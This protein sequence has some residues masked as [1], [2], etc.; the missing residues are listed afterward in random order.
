MLGDKSVTLHDIVREIILIRG[1]LQRIGVNASLYND[2][3]KTELETVRAL[4]GETIYDACVY[5]E[6]RMMLLRAGAEYERNYI[7][8]EDGADQICVNA[9]IHVEPVKNVKGAFDR[10]VLREVWAPHTMR[11]MPDR[12]IVRDREA[13]YDVKQENV[14][15]WQESKRDMRV[16]YYVGVINAAVWNK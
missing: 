9:T 11:H 13:E 15:K 8:K 2:E 3:R 1:T 16:H 5:L 10:L 7:F 12:T 14:K 6:Q 4:H